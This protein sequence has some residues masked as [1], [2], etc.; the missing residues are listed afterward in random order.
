[1]LAVT[2]IDGEFRNHLSLEGS[3]ATRAGPKNPD[4]FGFLVVHQ[5]HYI[6][7]PAVITALSRKG[8]VL[9]CNRS[10]VAARIACRAHCAF[11]V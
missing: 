10:V 8:G 1:M 11:G 2:L 6:G 3:L 7:S 5:P 9:R 4:E